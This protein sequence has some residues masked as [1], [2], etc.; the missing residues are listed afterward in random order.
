MDS[1]Q[2][3]KY[4]IAILFAFFTPIKSYASEQYSDY[5]IRNGK[6]Y[7]LELEEVYEWEAGF[8]QPYLEKK[9]KWQDFFSLRFYLE[10]VNKLLLKLYTSGYWC[11]ALAR[12]YYATLE[13]VNNKLVLKDISHCSGS[14]FFFKMKGSIFKM[15]WFTDSLIITDNSKDKCA[16]GFCEYYSVLHFEKGMLVKEERIGYKE[17]IKPIPEEFLYSYWDRE[18]DKFEHYLE[19]EKETE[20]EFLANLKMEY[21]KKFGEPISDFELTIQEIDF[22]N[23]YKLRITRTLYGAQ[24]RYV[25]EDS[26][27][28]IEVRLSIEE[29]LDF[30]RALYTCCFD[31]WEKNPVPHH[32]YDRIEG[33]LWVS[34]SSKGKPYTDYYRW[35][36]ED[37]PYNRIRVKNK[38]PNLDEFEKAMKDM[39]AKIESLAIERARQTANLYSE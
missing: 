16:Y 1:K 14:L 12:G 27:E 10:K 39:I 33:V 8:L 13:I 29:W 25:G 18:L 20:S 34:F 35:F 32:Y 22:W 4:L 37:Y 21:E 28:Q 11:S 31:K 38:L 24:A 17:Y 3:N 9:N 5:L 6:K 19:T 2:V 23:K 30:I 7:A 15:D 26:E 36:I